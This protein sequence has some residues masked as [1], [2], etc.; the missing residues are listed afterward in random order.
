MLGDN[1]RFTMAHKQRMPYTAACITE[2]QRIANVVPMN[3]QHR[4][5]N[6]VT[7]GKHHIPASKWNLVGK[8]KTKPIRYSLHRAN[9]RCY[10]GRALF[11]RS[12][13]L[14]TTALHRRPVAQRKSNAILTRQASVPGRESGAYGALPHFRHIASNIQVTKTLYRIVLWL[15]TLSASNWP[16]ILTW[17]RNASVS[18]PWHLPTSL[19]WP[20][21]TSDFVLPVAFFYTKAP[22]LEISSYT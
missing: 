21:G 10:G 17:A 16:R 22:T 2:I 7:V 6:D 14:R 19:L 11:P 13:T 4:A 9:G 12:Q 3:L 1:D 20:N 8:S 15:Q 5:G 18:L